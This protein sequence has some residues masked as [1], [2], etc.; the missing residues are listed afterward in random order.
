[1]NLNSIKQMLFC[2]AQD[3]SAAQELDAYT[4]LGISNILDNTG[5]EIEAAYGELLDK[6]EA[7]IKRYRKMLV[8]L[9][10]FLESH[11]LSCDSDLAKILA[12]AEQEVCR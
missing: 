8:E 6:H 1:M 4:L 9:S 2:I 11:G 12:D 5:H 3:D 10:V 7:M